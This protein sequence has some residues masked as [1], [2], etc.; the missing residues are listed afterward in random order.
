MFICLSA[1]CASTAVCTQKPNTDLCLFIAVRELNRI[2]HPEISQ[3]VLYS[4]KCY[5]DIATAWSTLAAQIQ[6]IIGYDYVKNHEQNYTAILVILFRHGQMRWLV[7]LS[8]VTSMHNKIIDIHHSKLWG[9]KYF[10]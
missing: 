3:Y 2:H 8:F 9:Q 4:L 10:L 7:K 5:C 1:C 6:L